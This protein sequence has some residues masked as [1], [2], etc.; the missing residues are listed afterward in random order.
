MNTYIIWRNSTAETFY[1]SIIAMGERYV[2]PIALNLS[3]SLLN[4]SFP[5]RFSRPSA[6]NS[7]IVVY[8]DAD[9]EYLLHEIIFFVLSRRHKYFYIHFSIFE[10]L[11]LFP[12]LWRDAIHFRVN[13]MCAHKQNAFWTSVE[14]LLQNP[15]SSVVVTLFSI[16]FPF[17]NS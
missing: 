2:W 17:H 14:P 10:N 13:R 8:L 6:S 5:G 9:W 16:R 7:S 15:I 3:C 12:F 11:F 1:S 4:N